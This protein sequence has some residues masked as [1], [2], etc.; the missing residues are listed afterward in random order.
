MKLLKMVVC[1]CCIIAMGM[2]YLS[3]AGCASEPPVFGPTKVKIWVKYQG[4]RSD[5][6]IKGF[7]HI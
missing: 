2:M 6:V 3:L 5:T 1:W 7:Q 4:L